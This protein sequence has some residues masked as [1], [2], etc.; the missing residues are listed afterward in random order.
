MAKL[1]SSLK[2]MVLSLG[3]ISLIAS[4]VLAGGYTLTKEPIQK[5][6]M[7]K[8]QDAIE[9]VLPIKDAKVGE[10]VEIKLDGKTD[11]F[12]IYPAEK[13]GKLVGAAIQTYSYDGYAGKIEVMVGLDNEGI[14]SNYTI[15]AASETPGLGS[16]ITDWFKTSKANQDIRGKNLSQT[17]LAVKKDGGEIDAITASTISSRAFLS[18]INSA[19]EAFKKYQQ[20]N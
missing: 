3:I 16:K 10:K 17:K 2:N 4:A 12:F 13:D 7:K 1:D 19:F 5:A 6:Q 11:A 15:L 20:Q 18:S 14:V 9:E 8:Q